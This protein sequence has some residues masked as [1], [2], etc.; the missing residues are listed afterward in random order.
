MECL[1]CKNVNKPESVFC[2]SCG[3][4]LPIKEL[5]PESSNENI[6]LS[7]SLKN[8][9]NSVY[10]IGWL[11]LLINLGLYLWTIVVILKPDLDLIV[12]QLKSSSLIIVV[13]IVY[14]ILGNRIRKTKDKNTKSYLLVLLALSIITL[15]VVVITGGHIGI[16]FFVIF[17]YLISS[18]FKI[19]KAMAS[20][21]ASSLF[22]NQTHKIKQGGW[23]AFGIIS[24]VFLIF[25]FYID[26]NYIVTNL[27]SATPL[28]SNEQQIIP[29]EPINNPTSPSADSTQITF[30]QQDINQMVSEIK[31]EMVFP[32]QVDEYTTLTDITAEPNAIRYHNTLSNVDTTELSNKFMQTLLQENVC[33]NPDTFELLGYGIAM[34]YSYIVKGSSEKYFV[35][36]LSSDCV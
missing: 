23:V 24:I 25:S 32:S 6:K 9:G 28:S 13:S 21:E 22:E 15:V 34:E 12:F 4:K 7:R 2:N 31:S 14:I 27:E 33:N 10:A 19:N 1:Q 20:S 3:T 11:T 18:Y 26:Q 8:T 5:A 17:A 36:I 35:K 16:L 29:S 30:G